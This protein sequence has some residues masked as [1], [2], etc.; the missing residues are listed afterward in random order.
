MLMGEHAHTIDSKGRVILPSEFR[1]ELGERFVITRGF[2]TCLSI[3][4]DASWQ[5]LT[6]KLTSLA[7]GSKNARDM[8]RIFVS[9]ARVLECDRQGRFLVPGNLRKFA[10]LEKDVV[11][12]GVINRI[13]VWSKAEWERYNE[14]VIPTINNLA[15]SLANLGF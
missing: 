9:V 15:E 1:E 5:I 12:I 14:A 7:V 11:L 3:Y 2:D 10:F 4:S 8:S 6:E 13:E